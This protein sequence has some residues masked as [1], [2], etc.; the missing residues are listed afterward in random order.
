MLCTKMQPISRIEEI[1][2]RIGIITPYKAQVR[3]IKDL[4][5]PWL[6]GF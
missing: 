1:K 2:G 5:A 3:L 4:L 6:R